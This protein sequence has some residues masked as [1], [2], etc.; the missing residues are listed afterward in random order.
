MTTF[1]KRLI[2]AIVIGAVAAYFM[3]ILVNGFWPFLM[4]PAP[5]VLW[6]STIYFIP[7]LVAWVRQHYNAPAI[8]ILNLLLG[9]TGLGWA[10][11]LVWAATNP[12][13]QTKA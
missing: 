6:A 13:V 10:V 12:G 8:I 1:Q 9:W 2:A 11:A 7:A 4:A 3:P 5:I